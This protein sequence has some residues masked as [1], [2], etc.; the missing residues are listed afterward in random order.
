MLYIL[1][2]LM[3]SFR[4]FLE[5][6]NHKILWIMRGVAGSGKSHKAKQLAGSTGA[7]FGTDDYWEPNYVQNFNAAI[8]NNTIQQKLSEYHQKNYERAIQAMQKGITPI[9]IDNTNIRKRDFERYVQAGESLGYEV[10]FAE[11]DHP[12]W[13]KIRPFIPHDVEKMQQAAQFFHR[14][15]QHG[16]P[17]NAIYKMMSSFEES[18]LRQLLQPV[19]QSPHWHKEGNVFKH[20]WLEED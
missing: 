1:N 19:P 20:S 6:N 8:A 10:R 13:K 9:V 17:A 11:S 7:I 14:N 2:S 15:N 5:E 12:E 18:S 3:K 16:V 4:I